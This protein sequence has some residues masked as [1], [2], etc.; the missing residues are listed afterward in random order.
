MG[1]QADSQEN[2]TDGRGG[3]WAGWARWT[4]T[5][6]V[7]TQP[8]GLAFAGTDSYGPSS[9]ARIPGRTTLWAVGGVSRTP[10]A[11]VFDTLIANYGPVH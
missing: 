4:G 9:Y 1:V 6:W 5:R 10:A 3:V 7:N 2:L 11:H 8:R